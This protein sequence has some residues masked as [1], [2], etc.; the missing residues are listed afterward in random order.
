MC[1]RIGIVV[2]AL[3]MCMPGMTGMSARAA[4]A[5]DEPDRLVAAFDIAPQVATANAFFDYLRKED[6]TDTEISFANGTSVD[7]LKQQVWYWA[8][9]W[10]YDVQNYDKAKEYSLK[11]LPL[12]RWDNEDKAYCLNLIAI[13]YVRQGD[14]S[15]AAKYAGRSVAINIRLGDPDRASS[16]LNTLAGIYMAGNHPEQARKYI[17]QALEY[18]GK[19]DNPA[20]YAVINGMASEVFYKLGDFARSLGYAE[21]AFRI[22]SVMGNRGKM[23][24]R[25]SEIGAALGGLDRNDEAV[26]AYRRAMPVLR[27]VG[28]LH[29]LG[30]DL[31]QL[32]FILMKQNKDREAV[33]C[34]REA[35]A[36]FDD[37]GDLYNGCLAQKGLYEAYWT[38]DPDSARIELNHFNAMR[39]SLYSTATAEALARYSA[40]F[41][42][43]Q[44]REEFDS[45]VRAH[46][47]DMVVGII[48]IAVICLAA[49]MFYRFK[50]R[51]HREEIRA[52][53]YEIE[54]AGSTPVSDTSAMFADE[55][56]IEIRVRAVVN[57]ALDTGAVSVKAV[58]SALNLGEQ[59]FRRRFVEET[60]K[61]PK[62]YIT[63]IQMERAGRLLTEHPEAL[64]SEVARRCGFDD[65]STFST[66]FKKTFNCSPSQFRS[67]LQ[68]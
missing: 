27:E 57:E 45:Q 55:P 6:F 12:Y 19:A 53:I 18:A 67:N 26:A 63:A 22:D 17:L 33:D 36:I 37:M 8:G 40:E 44:L 29:S 43:K 28:N 30:I 65:A 41:G 61:Q 49:Y 15:N 66:A 60:G 4:V 64:I 2:V 38:L 48:L 35:A 3:M 16:S 7:S 14:F 31:N 9:E 34:F 42:N 20:R 25:L 11:A 24:I 13:I 21:T 56:S 47:R 52:L 58:A 23:A 46:R 5:N 59:T 68:K 62:T 54:H 50:M 1:C 32:G 51:R 10:F 39:D